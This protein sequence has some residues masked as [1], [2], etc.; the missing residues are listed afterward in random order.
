MSMLDHDS[1]RHDFDMGRRFRRHW[2]SP[3]FVRVQKKIQMRRSRAAA[4][5]VIETELNQIGMLDLP[6]YPRSLDVLLN[7]IIDEGWQ[8]R[9]DCSWGVKISPADWAA[10]EL[11]DAIFNPFN[12]DLNL[13]DRSGD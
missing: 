2:N 5:R 4:R 12:Q 6:D 9:I 11:Y 10:L 7:Q 1:V 8:A 3:E 13:F